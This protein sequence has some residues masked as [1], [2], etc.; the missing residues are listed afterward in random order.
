GVDDAV[1][2]FAGDNS[3]VHQLTDQPVGD[4]AAIIDDG[5]LVGMVS[6]RDVADSWREAMEKEI[7][8][9]QQSIGGA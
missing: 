8:R 4:V 5:R 1:I 3:G 6:M 7:E 2:R 9:L